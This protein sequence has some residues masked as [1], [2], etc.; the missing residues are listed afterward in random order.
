MW[1]ERQKLPPFS[2]LAHCNIPYLFYNFNWGSVAYLR[3]TKLRHPKKQ[4]H[5]A[6]RRLQAST[7]KLLPLPSLYRSKYY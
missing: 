1:P 6:L 2:R 7:E 3:N 4:N 5:R